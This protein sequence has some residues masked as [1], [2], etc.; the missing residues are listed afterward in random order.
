MNDQKKTTLLILVLTVAVLTAGIF[1]VVA[2]SGES[3]NASG[4]PSEIKIGGVF[5]IVKRPDAGRDRRDAFL[6]AISEINNQTGAN[7]ILPEGVKLVPIVK[8]DDNSAAGG[9]AAAQ[10]LIAEGVH[11]VIGSSGSSVS[12]AMAAELGP[13]KIPQISYAASSPS[14]SDRTLYPYFMRVAASDA[15][16][17]KAIGDLVS[18]FGWKKGATIHTSDSYGVGLISVFAEIFKKNGGVIITDQQFDPGATDVAAQAQSLVDSNP[19]FI[20]GHFIDVDAATA[21][22]KAW[23][24]GAIRK[25]WI[26]TDG[27]STT[28]TFAN[29]D[30]V[31]KGMQHMIG[32]TPAPLT[33][34]GY[35]AFNQSWFDPEWNFLEGPSYSLSS[36][37]VF[38][39]YAPLS[40]DSVYVAAMGLAAANTT[41]GET[42]LNV[43]YNVTYD[44]AS[45]SIKFNEY[46]EVIGR[47]DYVQLDGETYTTFG[48]WQGTITLNDGEITLPDGS[49]W[50]I[51]DN[52]ATMNKNIQSEKA[53]PGLG[54]LESL[55]SLS[56]VILVTVAIRRKGKS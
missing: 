50:T 9:T 22:K 5:P 25:P 2:Q 55:I 12:A 47:Y 3:E 33:G 17:G 44:G 18:V 32:T 39:A 7:R 54:V 37:K 35:Q 38:N 40:Y 31:K 56:L 42:L 15:D 4:L 26:T 53:T 6:M 8:D 13:Q 52:K 46:G 1:P 45:G 21:V 30:T 24:V 51:S 29:D 10:A 43:L 16:Q 28:A 11:I 34:A 19:E 36:G 23:E 48:K 49:T 20:L 41:D 14:L 27:W